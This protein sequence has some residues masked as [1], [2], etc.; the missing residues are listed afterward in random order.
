[1]KRAP[2]S[3]H[4]I[5]ICFAAALAVLTGCE[6]YAPA[7]GGTDEVNSSFYTTKDDFMARL[8]SIVPGM[9]QEDV[10]ANLGRKE[11]DLIRLKRD[12][13]LVA[14]LG[15]NN[16][17]LKDNDL[18]QDQLR[19]LYGYKLSYRS[20][21]RKHGFAS[22]IR[23]QTDEKGFDYTITLIFRDGVLFEKPIITGGVVNS[24]STKT[25][26]D[27]LTPGSIAGHAGW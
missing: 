5:T 16:I 23:V 3:I 19:S 25:F 10:L 8:A 1:M 11:G 26:F 12:E 2:F 4:I 20:V 6:G 9:S 14:L 22:P 17:T 27:L 21:E 15:T 18:G 24:S 7:P 13:V